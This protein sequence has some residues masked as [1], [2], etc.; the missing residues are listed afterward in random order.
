MLTDTMPEKDI[1]T[2]ANRLQVP[3]I[4]S[5]I[6]NDEGALT[7]DVYLGLH[8][9]LSDDQPDSAL[10]SIALS[11]YAMANKFTSHAGTFNIL[12][13][14]CERIITEYG[15]MWLRNAQSRELDDNMIFDTLVHIPED[16]ECLAELL[17]YVQV[18][19]RD[20]D[21]IAAN[22]CEI[23]ITQ[24]SAQ[25][26]IAETFL[27]TLD[28]DMDSEDEAPWNMDGNLYEGED[29][30]MGALVAEQ[31]TA[32]PFYTDNVIPFPGTRN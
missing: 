29:I 22:L 26:M 24:A 32:Q 5:D 19:L 31:Q 8:E 12:K 28:I 15:M 11:A 10:L 4:I 1:A 7:D 6:L 9:I 27:E 25:T 21:P 3:L 16:L 23:L 13:M 17:E 20:H 18:T 30:D 2:I 14:E